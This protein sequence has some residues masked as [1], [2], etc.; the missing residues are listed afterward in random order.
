MQKH[1]EIT[2]D[3]KQNTDAN[4]IMKRKKIFVAWD[5]SIKNVVRINN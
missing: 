5:R 4:D 3:K 1:L 2:I